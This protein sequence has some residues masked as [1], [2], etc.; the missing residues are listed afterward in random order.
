MFDEE[1]D[2]GAVVVVRRDAKQAVKGVGAVL[3]FAD[4]GRMVAGRAGESVAVVA[5]LDGELVIFVPDAHR[6]L[7]G[8][9]VLHDVVEGFLEKQEEVAF[10]LDGE[11]GVD[12]AGLAFEAEAHFAQQSVRGL[13]HAFDQITN[14]VVAAFPHPDDVAH[15]E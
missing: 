10:G 12:L 14:R 11:V 4:C 7:I 6:Y 5:D 15:G 1:L 13:A 9:R 3:E 8:A 2:A